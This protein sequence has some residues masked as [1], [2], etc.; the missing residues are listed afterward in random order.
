MQSIEKVTKVHPLNP[1][2][3]EFKFVEFK[4]HISLA[5]L[6]ISITINVETLLLC[7]ILVFSGLAC[8][9]YSLLGSNAFLQWIDQPSADWHYMHK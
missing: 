7:K 8:A 4:R 3:N 5:L 1:H 9:P 2:F 6:F